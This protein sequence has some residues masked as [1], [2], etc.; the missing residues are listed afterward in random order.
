MKNN[1]LILSTMHLRM[2]YA[3]RDKNHKTTRD[4]KMYIEIQISKNVRATVQS[5]QELLKCHCL[6]NIYPHLDLLHPRIKSMER[7]TYL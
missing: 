3:A 7:I 6:A 1:L 5:G 2:L 4:I